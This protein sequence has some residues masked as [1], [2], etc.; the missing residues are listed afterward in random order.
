MNKLGVCGSVLAGLVLAQ[1]LAAMDVPSRPVVDAPELARLG[2]L[3]VGVR[4]QVLVDHNAVDVLGFDPKSGQPPR[5][6]RALTVDIWYP[7]NST[8]DAVPV[9]YRASQ[10]AEPPA[11]PPEPPEEADPH[12]STTDTVTSAKK[13]RIGFF[14]AISFLGLESRSA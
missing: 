10:P 2:E 12:P 11:P 9:T 4:T 5:R 1:G 6:D 7:V 8:V 14:I 13:M 3:A